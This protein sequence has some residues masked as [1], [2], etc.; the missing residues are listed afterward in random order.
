MVTTITT[1]KSVGLAYVL[2]FFLGGLGIHRFYLG[3]TGSG[4]GMLLLNL[5][6]WLTVWIMIGGVFLF[7]WFIWWIVDAFLIPGMAR[8][9]TVS[10]T[11]TMVTRE[12]PP[13]E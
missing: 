9:Q 6:G 13:H 12:I 4:V 8:G 10:V 11:Q 5:V 2:W 3:R 7:A 1:P